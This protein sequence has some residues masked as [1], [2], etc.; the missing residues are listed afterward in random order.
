[1]GPR[2]ISPPPELLGQSHH[3]H[4]L[5]VDM[6]VARIHYVPALA[7]PVQSPPLDPL[8][9]AHWTTAAGYR[10]APWVVALIPHYHCGHVHLRK[11]SLYRDRCICET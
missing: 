10:S 2:L 11:G 9:T 5:V 3:P 4:Q 7:V 6:S 1:M 8:R